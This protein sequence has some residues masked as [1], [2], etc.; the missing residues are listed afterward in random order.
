LI[1]SL[2]YIW[3]SLEAAARI[4]IKERVEDTEFDVSEKGFWTS[5]SVIILAAPIQLYLSSSRT[6]NLTALAETTG[7]TYTVPPFAPEMLSDGIAYLGVWIAY[8]LLMIFLAKVMKVSERYAPYIIARN[9]SNLLI[10]IV[11]GAPPNAIFRLGLIESEIWTLMNLI[12]LMV[13][14]WYLWRV[15]KCMLRVNG[16]QAASL[17]TFDVLLSF[18]IFETS[19]V[20]FLGI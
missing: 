3:S 4:A 15:A 7:Q 9:W 1:P 14:I 6:D 13:E 12:I 2:S 19:R 10:Y 20:F 16:G 8:P 11:L 17:V 5:F 18:L